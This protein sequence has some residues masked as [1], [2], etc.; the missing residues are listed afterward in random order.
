M[1]LV[2]FRAHHV[3]TPALCRRARGER[4]NQLGGGHP[5]EWR[6]VDFAGCA[7]ERRLAPS[8]DRGTFYMVSI[9]RRSCRAL[10]VA[11]SALPIVALT[12]CANQPE[13]RAPTIERGEAP[14]QDLRAAAESIAQ[15]F[16]ADLQEMADR[17][18]G[19]SRVVVLLGDIANKTGTMSTNDFEIVQR[20]IRQILNR[21]RLFRENVQLRETARR[22]RALSEK[23][24]EGRT[25]EPMRQFEGLNVDAD[26]VFFLT[27]DAFMANRRGESLLYLEFTLV[28][29]SNAEMVFTRE[30]EASYRG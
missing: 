30:Y 17:S 15:A 10:L 7:G 6:A 5:C 21:D 22:V 18:F 29:E 1:P 9:V 25:S 26:K 20:K 16:A 19:D 27:G 23:E 14:I 3:Y 13:T 2:F 12:S 4:L 24:R 28:R 11:S 8:A